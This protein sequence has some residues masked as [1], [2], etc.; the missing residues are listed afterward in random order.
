MASTFPKF[1]VPLV[2]LSVWPIADT[3]EI[4]GTN[5][6]KILALVT[7]PS[8]EVSSSSNRDSGDDN[9]EHVSYWAAP[10]LSQRMQYPLD[11]DDDGDG[12]LGEWIYNFIE[13][14]IAKQQHQ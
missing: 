11:I 4:M 2:K 14:L 3:P 9:G 7:C 10:I 1:L 5:H 6:A 13:N 8:S 12:E